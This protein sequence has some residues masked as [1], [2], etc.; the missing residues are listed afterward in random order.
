MLA[1]MHSRLL[2]TL[3]LVAVLAGCKTKAASAEQ[4]EA[5]SVHVDTLEVRQAPMP[6]SLAL[7]GS[8]RGKRQTD[9]AAN[10]A[11]R[12]VETFVERGSEVKQGDLL[13][14][15]D[16]RAAALTA[17]EATANV[18]LARAQQDTAKREC[19]RY[20]ALLEKHAI[21]QSEFDHTADQCVSSP[22]SVAAAEDRAR[23]AAQTVGDG[24]IR[25]PF[26]GIVTERFIEA[27]EYVKQD[28]RI[29][30]L[31]AV[32]TL[33]LE[34]T[35]PEANLGSVKEGG[36]LTF[37][38]PAYPDRTFSGTVRFVGAA[39]RETTRDLVAE[40]VVDNPDRTLK[41]G[42]FATIALI[43]GELPELVL[44]KSAL[45]DKD[46]STHVFAVADGRLEERVVQIGVAKGD[47]VA[48]E[49]GLKAGDKVVSKPTDALH[50]GQ[51]V[52]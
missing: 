26:G 14:K 20:K 24:M 7:T 33:R 11:G 9:L 12:V 44:P 52:N 45:V 39:V 29:V 49:R 46:G 35:V 31:V 19:D 36:D 38:V 40:A 10:A 2:P 34:F 28:T 23:V 43:T 48:I 47:L 5:P 32:E 18:A 51:T 13:A 16:V 27:G 17:A 4:T 30:S 3:A 50:N 41:P 15:L 1:F 22:L 37:S 25:A 8:L 42:M 21:T 6:Q